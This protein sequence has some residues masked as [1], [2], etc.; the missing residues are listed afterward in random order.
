MAL[1]RQISSETDNL[2]CKAS[3]TG[4]IPLH[5]AA[6]QG[7][8]NVVKSLLE[9]APYCEHQ[10]KRE[11]KAGKTPLHVAAE[12]GEREWVNVLSACLWIDFTNINL[13]Q[14]SEIGKLCCAIIHHV[15]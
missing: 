9:K 8:L 3:K 14:N 15:Y 7:N 6:S 10:I 13:A 5:I 4:D 11:N 12:N 1:T 2:P